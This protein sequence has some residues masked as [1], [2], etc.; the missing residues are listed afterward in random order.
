M[1]HTVLFSLAARQKLE[2]RLATEPDELDRKTEE[3]VG[4]LRHVFAEGHSAIVQD[5]YTGYRVHANEY[6]LLVELSGSGDHDGRY[7][8]KLGPR[9]NLIKEL[10]AWRNCRPTG[11]RHDLVLMP[12]D[13]RPD[14]N[15]PVGLVYADAQ[16]F[17]GV[18][19]TLTLESALLDA[20]RV[21]FPTPESVGELL[22]QLYERLG[23][24]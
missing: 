5:L 19:Q 14:A 6:V 8:V 1:C 4:W 15:E 9:E 2:Q 16:Q 10:N 21:G 13:P 3:I 11:L 24:V 17:I 7:V 22:F 20:A 18:D 23:V 12:I